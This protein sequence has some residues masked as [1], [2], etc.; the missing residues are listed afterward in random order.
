[1]LIFLNSVVHNFRTTEI[2]ILVKLTAIPDF[3]EVLFP[4]LQGSYSLFCKCF[5]PYFAD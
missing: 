3:S 5:I 1:L 4:I 2:D